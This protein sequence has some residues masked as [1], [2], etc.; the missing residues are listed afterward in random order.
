[1]STKK[2]KKFYRPP[3]TPHFSP[4]SH[5]C[6]PKNTQPADSFGAFTL[7]NACRSEA[8]I[9][10]SLVRTQTR[11]QYTS[12]LDLPCSIPALPPESFL[13]D[14]LQQQRA[15][16]LSQNPAVSTKKH[17]FFLAMD[18]HPPHRAVRCLA[19]P[20]F[21]LDLAH[22]PRPGGLL[23]YPQRLAPRLVRPVCPPCSLGG[24]CQSFS[25]RRHGDAASARA[26]PGNLNKYQNDK[27]FPP[28]KSPLANATILPIAG[29]LHPAKNVEK[30]NA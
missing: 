8:K 23:T 18:S 26:Q 16:V 12:T 17:S 13:K 3:I 6:P 29:A 2:N 21:T 15:R 19:S 11:R 24:F 9:R 22:K 10:R 7:L 1:M 14:R 25:R 28:C 30:P 20:H 27:P 4:A 5:S